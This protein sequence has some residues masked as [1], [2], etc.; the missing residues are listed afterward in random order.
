MRRAGEPVERRSSAAVGITHQRAQQAVAY[1]AKQSIARQVEIGTAAPCGR[2]FQ[3]SPRTED[4][5]CNRIF[6]CC[7]RWPVTS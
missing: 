2:C 1:S 5:P 4:L 7:A 3:G 6:A